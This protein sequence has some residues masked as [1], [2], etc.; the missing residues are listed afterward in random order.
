VAAI[1]LDRT[2]G[3]KF[4]VQSGYFTL[5]GKAWKDADFL[6]E[7]AFKYLDYETVAHLCAGTDYLFGGHGVLVENL[8][9]AGT[10]E[11]RMPYDSANPYI[12]LPPLREPK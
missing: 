10:G 5:K 9:S 12:R 8:M 1:K 2:I 4:L 3:T 11:P 6:A 7:D